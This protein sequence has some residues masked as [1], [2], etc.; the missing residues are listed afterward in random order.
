MIQRIVWMISEFK[1]NFY[2]INVVSATSFHFIWKYINWNFFGFFFSVSLFCRPDRE[3]IRNQYHRI[4]VE[5]NPPK[6]LPKFYIVTAE[7]ISGNQSVQ[8]NVPSVSISD[9]K[10]YW[11]KSLDFWISSYFQS[12]K[13]VSMNLLLEPEKRYRVTIGTIYSGV[14]NE[15]KEAYFHVEMYSLCE[16]VR[17]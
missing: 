10:W 1:R 17:K 2:R 13:S 11:W 7:T 16:V 15:I 14:Q 4:D 12:E 8:M 5:W 3:C 6:N 9:A